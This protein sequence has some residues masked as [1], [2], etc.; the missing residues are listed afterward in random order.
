MLKM[1]LVT[2]IDFDRDNK[3]RIPNLLVDFFFSHFRQTL[4]HG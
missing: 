1:V 2:V 4:A 3:Q